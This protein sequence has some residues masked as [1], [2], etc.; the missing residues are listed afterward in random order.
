MDDIYK[1]QTHK[2]EK[3]KKDFMKQELTLKLKFSS[4]KK[5]SNKKL[6]IEHENKTTT[7]KKLRRD[8]MEERKIA[9]SQEIIGISSVFLPRHFERKSEQCKTKNEN[10]PTTQQKPNS[11]LYMSKNSLW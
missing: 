7:K 6:Q 2:N 1:F 11:S 5:Q 10:Q 9:V 4:W 8:S 3:K